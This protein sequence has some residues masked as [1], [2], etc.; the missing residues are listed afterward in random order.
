[1]KCG[2]LKFTFYTSHLYPAAIARR[3]VAGYYEN[4]DP[5]FKLFLGKDVS[6]YSLSWAQAAGAI[7]ST[8]AD[9]SVWARALYQGT[10]LLPRR[11]QE[12]LLRLIST[13]TAKPL[14]APTAED[15][16]AFGLG[17]AKRI[18]PK[19]GSFW[20]YQG[21]TLG[22]RAAHLYFPDSD[23][24]VSIFANSRPMESNSK[25]QELFSTVYATI[26]H[27]HN[28]P[29]PRLKISLP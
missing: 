1:V 8:P 13:K 12:E 29:R 18:T 5:G 17:V 20:F 3:V 25:L 11:Q 9:L 22:F 16:A 27:Y 14:A 23:L 26:N 6:G 28:N 19:L 21:E 15:P 4:D 10:K 24:V 2:G 7:V